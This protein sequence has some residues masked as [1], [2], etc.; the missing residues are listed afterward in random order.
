[1]SIAKTFIITLFTWLKIRQMI[2]QNTL[3][4]LTCLIR[5]HFICEA[6][7]I[8]YYYTI[9]STSVITHYSSVSLMRKGCFGSVWCRQRNTSPSTTPRCRLEHITNIMSMFSRLHLRTYVLSYFIY[10]KRKDGST[11]LSRFDLSP[12]FKTPVR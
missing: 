1:M 6:L 9:L 5:F 2:S 8:T 10:N 3:L 7:D 11:F 4:F 12:A